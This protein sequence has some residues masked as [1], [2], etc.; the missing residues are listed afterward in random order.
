MEFEALPVQYSKLRLGKK[1]DH[2]GGPLLR[3]VKR[4]PAHGTIVGDERTDGRS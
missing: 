2:Q 4:W 3:G 1:L